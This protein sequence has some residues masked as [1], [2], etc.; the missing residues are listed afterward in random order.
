MCRNKKCCPTN[1]A[2]TRFSC[3]S[4]GVRAVCCRDYLTCCPVGWICDIQRQL[5][6]T[7]VY[8]SVLQVQAMPLVNSTEKRCRDGAAGMDPKVSRIIPSQ[9]GEQAS[10]RSGLIGT[11]G[12]V[13]SRDEKNQCPDGTTI[14][15]LSSGTYGCC[16]NE[17]ARP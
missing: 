16:T 2:R 7:P 1:P 13:F 10:K 17:N 4:I 12:E 5:C 3:C 8:S 9:Q 15:E 6:I 14:C 11:S